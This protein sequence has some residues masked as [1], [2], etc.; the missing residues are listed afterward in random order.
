MVLTQPKGNSFD[1]GNNVS[2]LTAEAECFRGGVQDTD[3]ITYKWYSLNLATQTWVQL[4]QD[5]ATTAGVST[6]TVKASDV[7]N[8]QTFKC[9]AIDGTDRSEAI[10]TFEDRT[11][12]YSVEIFSPTGLQ[13]KNGQGSTTLCARV[14]RGTEKIEDEATATK[15]LTYTWTKFD[16]NGTK[17]NFAGT[18]SAQKTGNPLIVSAT[19]IDSKATFYCEVSI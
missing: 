6:L 11:D 16:K 7:L 3:G 13:I 5:I 10:V 9:E 12:P 14:Y 8:V 1:A 15:K 17:S 2:T 4:S 19:D 18:T